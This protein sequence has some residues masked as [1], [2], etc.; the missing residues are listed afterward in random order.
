MSIVQAIRTV[1][2][3]LLLSS[4][5][6]VWGTLS[7]LIAPFLPFRA[8]YRFIA[9]AW[10]KFAVW[11]AGV[12]VGVRYELK[13]AENIPDQPCVILAKHQSTW[14]TF[15][16]TGYFEPLSQVLKR[17]LL[18]VPFF[19]WAMALLK[20][21]AINREQ[22]KL[23]LKQIAKQGDERLKQG[24]WVLIFPEGTRVPTG[25]IGKF[26]R[27]GAALAVNANLP[28]LPIAHNAGHCWPKN[29][30]AKF[31]GTIQVVIGPAM[32]AEGEGARAITELNQRAENWVAQT[33]REMGELP[34]DATPQAVAE[35]S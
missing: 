31:P 4:S 25:Q 23:A 20:P 13:G 28:V 27:G 30:W 34:V 7:L 32:Y 5:A 10:C 33:L 11:L 22:P 19:G 35:A 15:F 3:Y 26:S 2:F 29:G 6:F 14:E 16:L 21:I 17:E 1:L 24:A 18:F 8:R 12:M 9:Q